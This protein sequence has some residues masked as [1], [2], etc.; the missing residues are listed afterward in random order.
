MYT[1][2]DSRRSAVFL[3][4]MIHLLVGLAENFCSRI[5]KKSQLKIMLYSK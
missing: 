3:P 5:E 2:R 4:A 1:L